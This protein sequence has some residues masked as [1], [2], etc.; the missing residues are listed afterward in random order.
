MEHPERI[1]KLLSKLRQPLHIEYICK[2]VLKTNIEDCVEILGKLKDDGVI[3]EN[4]HFY[5]IKTN[6]N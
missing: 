6:D 5:K 1:K 2:N 4:N 3:E